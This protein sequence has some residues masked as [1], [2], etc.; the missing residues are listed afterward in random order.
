[1]RELLELLL[2]VAQA[3]TIELGELRLEREQP[4]LGRGLL[5]SCG[6]LSARPPELTFEELQAT[7]GFPSYWD[8]ELRYK[9][10]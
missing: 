2:E 3:L 5:T 4:R 6:L 8:A 9:V 7:V 10:D 1:M